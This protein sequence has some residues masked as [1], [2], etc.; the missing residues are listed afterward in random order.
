[1]GAAVRED[2]AM[3]TSLWAGT[4]AGTVAILVPGNGWLKVGTAGATLLVGALVGTLVGVLV[5]AAISRL[6][7]ETPI[8]AGRAEETT[9]EDGAPEVGRV[10]IKV[11]A[12]G[13]LIAWEG[14]GRGR[15]LVGATEPE[16]IV[17]NPLVPPGLTETNW[18]PRD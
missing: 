13:L 10:G 1:M 9:R 7:V 11:P 16:S 17:T 14:K 6:E 4:W 8:D 12:A 5:I 18:S 15:P 3:G 2:G